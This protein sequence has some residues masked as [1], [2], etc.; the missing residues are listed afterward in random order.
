[1]TNPVAIATVACLAAVSFAVSSVPTRQPT[2]VEA[3]IALPNTGVRLDMADPPC[4]D[5]AAGLVAHDVVVKAGA[6]AI[7]AAIGLPLEP[8]A[9]SHV[10]PGNS[11]WLA[12]RVGVPVEGP[13]T[14][15]TLCVIYPKTARAT[16]EACMSD[17]GGADR[18]C[19][20]SPRSYAGMQGRFGGFSSAITDE[21][22]VT[23][24]LGKNW[25]PE[26][27]RL[28]SVSATY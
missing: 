16:V 18:E 13:S 27:S 23:C 5:R 2:R 8:P 21:A 19:T 7:D 25:S 22:V 15:A 4:S 1:M 12:G 24:V 26:R 6:A 11:E 17:A 28:F 3:R 9:L 20:T 14:C 10:P